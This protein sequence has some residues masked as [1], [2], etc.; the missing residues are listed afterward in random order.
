M[1]CPEC[2][3]TLSQQETTCPACGWKIPQ[4]E[5]KEWVILGWICD[6]AF[7]ELAKETLKQTDIPSVIMSK[8][9]MFGAIGLTLTPLFAGSSGCFEISVPEEFAA[10]AADVLDMILG[11][12]WKKNE[13]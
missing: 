3:S 7:T 9:G 8:S 2:N 12:K 4:T 5:A 10:E 6:F 13:S 1:Q 11:E